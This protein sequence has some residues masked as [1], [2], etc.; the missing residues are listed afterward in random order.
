[1]INYDEVIN[2]FK[3]S[4]SI[5]QVMDFVADLG[6]EPQLK[7]EYFISKT[8]CHNH[9]GE[10]SHKLYY[11]D[12]TK[13][14]RC[15]TDCDEPVFD[16][17]DLI[18]R[19]KSLEGIDGW[20]VVDSVAF[21]ARYFNYEIKF[22]LKNNGFS[23]TSADWALFEKIEKTQNIEL[24]E[25]TI[26][27]RIFDETILNRLPHPRILPWEKEGMTESVIND[28][29]IAYDPLNQSII[30]PH[31]NIAGDLIG[32]RERVLVEEAEKRGKYKPAILNGQ[33]YNHPLG[34]NLY[35]LNHSKDNIFALKK[36]IVW[37]SEKSCLL[38]SSYFGFDNDITV[39][40]CGSSLT[41]FQFNLLRGLGVQEIIIGFD[42]QFQEIGDEEWTRWT[43]KLT[44][45]HSK[46][47]NQVQLSFLFDTENLLPYKASP[48]DMGKDVFLKMFEERKYL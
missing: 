33:M 16:I 26:E 4:L 9:K 23:S 30:I 3:N 38:Y 12:N 24:Q 6:G 37:E 7:N 2:K 47:G 8:I 39:A 41:N 48:I 10:G 21:A 31:Y 1:M 28:F 29:N 22:Q 46:Y 43:K 40:C 35:N 36:V 25:Q 34:F 32:I 14:F 18:T 44:D 15:Y 11:Y 42:K 17:F 5:E 45:F 13:L 20:T 27:Y 19:V